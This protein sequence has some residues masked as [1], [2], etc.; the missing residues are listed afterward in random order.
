M[1]RIH[2]AGSSFVTGDLI[3]RALIDYAHFLTAHNTSAS[4]DIPIRRPD[5]TVG[6]A[7]FL[8][9]PTS[10]LVSESEGSRFSELVDNELVELLHDRSIG[11]HDSHPR[12]VNELSFN[13]FSFDYSDL[14]EYA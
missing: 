12:P 3:A 14:A 5:G 13:A 10:Q 7:N 6:R 1:E 4:V 9:G 11:M 2:Y 8:L